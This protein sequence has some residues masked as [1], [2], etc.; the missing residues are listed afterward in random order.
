MTFIYY[1]LM[2]DLKLKIPHLNLQVKIPTLT[3]HYYIYRPSGQKIGP[4]PMKTHPYSLFNSILQGLVP[5]TQLAKMSIDLKFVKLTAD[6][7]ENTPE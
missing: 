1:F 3:Y 5:T 2:F 6:V 7:L 4:L